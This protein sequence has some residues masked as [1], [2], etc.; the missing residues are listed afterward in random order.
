MATSIATPSPIPASTVGTPPPRRVGTAVVVETEEA[1]EE[2][3]AAV[4][5]TGTT[6]AEGGTSIG[7]AIAPGIASA[8]D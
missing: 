5:A 7:M 3:V 2:V 6:A 4:E 8:S 1:E